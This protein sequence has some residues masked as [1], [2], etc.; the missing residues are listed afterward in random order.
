MSILDPVTIGAYWLI[1]AWIALQLF[2]LGFSVETEE[3]VAY[4]AHI[5]GALAGAL[6]I[7]VMRPSHVRLF[8]CISPP[9]AETKVTL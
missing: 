1:L 6:L 7:C 4:D 9:E 3:S 8:E 2:G 5:G